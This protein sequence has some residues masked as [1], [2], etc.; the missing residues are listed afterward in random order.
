MFLLSLGGDCEEFL[1]QFS[2]SSGWLHLAL[3]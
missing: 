1:G 3:V 2:L